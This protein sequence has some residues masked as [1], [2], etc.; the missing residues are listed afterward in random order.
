MILENNKQV[1]TYQN[2]LEQ[3]A[4]IDFQE[5]GVP[6]RNVVRALLLILVLLDWRI[7]VLVKLAPVDHLIEKYILN[8]MT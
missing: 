1:N 8:N 4:L 6:R 3:N 2:Q 5:F 7:V